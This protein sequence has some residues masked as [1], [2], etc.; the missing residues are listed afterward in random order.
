MLFLW[1]PLCSSGDSEGD[2]D[3][4]RRVLGTLLAE[5]DGVTSSGRAYLLACTN[6]LELIDPALLRPGRID[7][8]VHMPLPDQADRE[9]I[10]RI[11]TEKFG[12]DP[13]VVIDVARATHGRTCAELQSIAREAAIITIR[14]HGVRV[15][16]E[17]F[18]AA[19]HSHQHPRQ[20]VNPF[21]D[22]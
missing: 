8:H 20:H 11:H 4:E 15:T 18:L 6:R 12:L 9:A 1:F 14:K 10:L 2:S 21:G 13:Q 7:H 17:D 16:R 3:V 19:M 22:L 5:L